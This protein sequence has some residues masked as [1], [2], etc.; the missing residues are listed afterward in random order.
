M[1]LLQ[2]WIA[3]LPALI[4]VLT[5][6]A[7]TT[8]LVWLVNRVATLRFAHVAEHKLPQQVAILSLIAVGIIVGILVLPITEQTKAQLLSLLGLVITAIIAFSSTT[9]VTN[10][11]AGLML[12]TIRSFYPGD[13]IRAG[14]H[15]GRVTEQGLF[16][17]EIQTGNR[18]LTSIP[19]AFLV[20][21][22]VTVVRHSGTIIETTL[23]LGYDVSH[24]DAEELLLKAASNAGLEDAFVHILELG[25]FAITYRVAGFLGD[26]KRLVSAGTQ[27]R[28]AVLDT[29]HDA[30]VEVASPALMTQRRLAAGERLIPAVRLRARARRSAEATPEEI[31][32]DKAEEAERI[33]LL[34]HEQ[35]ELVK[36][37]KA[38]EKELADT[39]QPDREHL[40]GEIDRRRLRID[41]IGTELEDEDAG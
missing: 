37:I 19:N 31:V 33:A 17:T 22:P 4:P 36:E 11:M 6:A 10:A 26:T 35:A 34:R 12:R 20:T 39:A 38:L 32:F 9:L 13:F 29:L 23:S 2:E 16:H 30:D 25:N 3:A 8:V 41:A 15:F 40:Q 7:V 14:E 21:H 27:L 28:R 18:D 5:V 1:D 24:H